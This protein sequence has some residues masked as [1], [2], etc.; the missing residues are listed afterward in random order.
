VSAANFPL[1]SFLIAF[2]LLGAIAVGFSGKKEHARKIAVSIA[3]IELIGSLLVLYCFNPDDGQFQ[4]LER[5]SW[6][7]DLNVEYLLG[8][9]GISV[10]FLPMSAFVT[11]MAIVASWNSIQHLEPFHY[12]LLLAL[13]GITIGVFT[14]VFPVLGANL[15]PHIL[16]DRLVGYWSASAYGSRQVYLVYVIWR[17]GIIDCHCYFGA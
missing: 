7:P 3:V 15:T 12:A 11:L 5:H 2:P 14:A 13:E 17:C 16:F 4:L 9:D 8:V 6:I 10:L 1:L